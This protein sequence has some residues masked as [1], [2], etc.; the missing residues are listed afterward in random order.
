MHFQFFFFLSCCLIF[1][2][3]YFLSSDESYLIDDESENH[4]SESGSSGTYYYCAFYLRFIYSVGSVSGL[5]SG[6][7]LPTGVE[8]KY[9][10]FAFDVFIPI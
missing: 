4:G 5:G 7:F 10:I 2:L 8:S 1:D 6:V 3:L 9:D